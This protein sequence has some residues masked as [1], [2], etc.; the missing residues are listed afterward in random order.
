VQAREGIVDVFRGW[1]DGRLGLRL[2]GGWGCWRC[3][4]CLRR[5]RGGENG[6]F[7]LPP[8]PPSLSRWRWR[9]RPRPRVRRFLQSHGLGF[10]GARW[11]EPGVEQAGRASLL[12]GVSAVARPIEGVKS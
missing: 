7:A 5:R 6:S 9:P 4:G 1:G 12:P 2:H 10:W 11:L 3:G 8:P